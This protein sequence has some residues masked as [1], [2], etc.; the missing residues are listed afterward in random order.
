M[1][2]KMDIIK[3]DSEEEVSHS[4]ISNKTFT[5]K[6]KT[7][8]DSK[9]S[10][11]DSFTDANMLENFGLKENIELQMN[12][13]EED[14][15]DLRRETED[16]FTKISIIFEYRKSDGRDQDKN[17]IKETNINDSTY[18]DSLTSAASLY[19][20]LNSNK[21]KLQNDLDKYR[22]SIEIQE[23][24]KRDVYK[25]LMN[26]K[27]ELLINAES[28]KGT[29]ITQE[30]IETWLTE[31]KMLEDE[32]KQF[33]IVNIKN[34]LELNRLNKE[35]KKLEEYF[36]GLHLIDFEQLKI[37]NNTL[38]EKIEDRN[39][40]IEKLRRKI[41]DNV[42]TL[43]HIQE[44]YSDINA[45]FVYKEGDKNVLEADLNKNK[46][47]HSNLREKLKEGSNIRLMEQKKVD[48]INSKD[49]KKFY[50]ETNMNILGLNNEIKDT[51]RKLK[52]YR[53]DGDVKD[54]M[55]L[56]RRCMKVMEEYVRMPKL[57]K[58][59]EFKK[60]DIKYD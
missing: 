18:T 28:K 60:E 38:T 37:E 39:E 33:R 9:K 32:I 2:G 8:Q 45:K 41:K 49:L 47:A 5:S 53:N 3:E 11:D 15:E 52:R 21:K 34:S 48:T 44:K 16:F 14:I 12:R 23:E 4:A 57:N 54:L 22:Q 51:L 40:E 6:S 55:L 43:A 31:E 59:E 10:E 24:R 17:L 36:E 20:D 19:N 26:Y 50:S 58:I 27:Q 46:V 30:Q 56:Q 35:L 29:K 1:G 7:E 42:Q 13:K 25:I